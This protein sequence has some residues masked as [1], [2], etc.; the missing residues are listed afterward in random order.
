MMNGMHKVLR[1]FIPEITVPFLDHVPIKGCAI[2]DKDES[3]NAAGCRKFVVEHVNDCEKILQR[4]EDVH[5]TFSGQKSEFWVLEVFIVGH[6]CGPYG[7]K[8]SPKKIDAI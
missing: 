8:P 7:R 5:L 4:L 6:M 1:Y 2:E 3:I